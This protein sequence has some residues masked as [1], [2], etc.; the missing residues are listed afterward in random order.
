MSHA[1]HTN[2]SCC[3]Y[4]SEP[5]HTYEHSHDTIKEGFDKSVDDDMRFLLDGRLHDFG[6]RGCTSVE[7]SILGGSA[8][9]LVHAF[10]CVT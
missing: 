7:Q 9:L 4:M 5:C 3:T 2:E 10:I 1:T 6:F 8:H